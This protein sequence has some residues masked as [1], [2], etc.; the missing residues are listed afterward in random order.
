MF[1]SERILSLDVGA[2]GLKLAEF[3]PLKAGGVEMVKYAVGALNF[4][5]HGDTDRMAAITSTLLEMMATSGIKP[6]PVQ[7]PMIEGRGK[8]PM[9]I[10]AEKA[11]ARIAKAVERGE[12]T[13]YVPGQWW[14]IMHILQHMPSFIFK[15]LSI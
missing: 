3:I 8:M 1:K 11:A 10:S 13:V 15:R 2:S 7:T 6:G 5:P 9:T 14:L 12:H 4:D